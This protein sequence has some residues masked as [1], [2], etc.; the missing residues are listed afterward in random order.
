MSPHLWIYCDY[1]RLDIKA[2]KSDLLNCTGAD[3]DRANAGVAKV[4]GLGYSSK[5][6][7]I[8]ACGRANDTLVPNVMLLTKHANGT[9]NLWE[10]KCASNLFR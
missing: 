1:G 7:G 9:L 10:V 5:A 2:L 4:A 3:P 6:A 8:E